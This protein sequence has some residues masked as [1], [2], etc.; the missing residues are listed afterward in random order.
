MV[1]W[2]IGLSGS[3]KTT[4]AKIISNKLKNK[5]VHIDGDTIRSM[6]ENKLGYTSRDRLLNA[7]RISRL[8][9]I[10]S[11]Q[12]V[13]ILVSVL[14]NFPSWLYWNRKNIRKYFLRACL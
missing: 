4:L 1:I 11:K 10:L 9:Q 3:G 14:S 13:N 7:G 8:V 12:K 5:I 6:Y 2:I